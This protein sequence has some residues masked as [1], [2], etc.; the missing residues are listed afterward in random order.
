MTKEEIKEKFDFIN[1]ELAKIEHMRH[2][3]F[4]EKWQ[5]ERHHFAKIYVGKFWKSDNGHLTYAYCK[6]YEEGVVGSYVGIFDYFKILDDGS[7]TFQRDHKEH[8][9]SKFCQQEITQKEYNEGF[10]R[11]NKLF[12]EFTRVKR[13]VLIEKT[14]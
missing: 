2:E 11:F 8:T 4:R 5:L 10:E 6:G 13:E 7:T 9:M 12:R 14:I 1:Q 3:L